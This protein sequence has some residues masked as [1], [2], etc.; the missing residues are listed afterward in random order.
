M[1]WVQTAGPCWYTLT[2]GVAPRVMDEWREGQRRADGR[3]VVLARL[4]SFIGSLTRVCVCACVRVCVYHT[5]IE[6]PCVC[7]YMS[8]DGRT[9][10]RM[11]GQ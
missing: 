3:S 4:T 6:L 7:V 2:A 9:D 8:S 11:D 10:G 1:S 5:L